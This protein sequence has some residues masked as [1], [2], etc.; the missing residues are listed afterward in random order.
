VDGG[1][2]GLV[3]H[4][5]LECGVSFLLT[6]QVLLRLHLLMLEGG[7][8]SFQICQPVFESTQP[9]DQFGRGEIGAGVGNIF[10]GACNY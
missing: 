6:L 8:L 10:V 9:L 1:R 7:N 3:R 2:C 4:L 5:R